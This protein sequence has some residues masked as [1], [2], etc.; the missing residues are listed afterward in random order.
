MSVLQPGDEDLDYSDNSHRWLSP[1]Q[2][3]DE[4]AWFERVKAHMAAH[5]YECDTPGR[6][7]IHK[8]RE[9]RNQ[10]R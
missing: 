7:I 2:G 4:D 5:G 1:E 10:G 3:V 6:L 8:L 9:P